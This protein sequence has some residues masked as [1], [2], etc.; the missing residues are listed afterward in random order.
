MK[1]VDFTSCLADE[2][3]HFVKFKQG[4]GSDYHSCAKLLFRFDQHLVALSFKSK[5]PTRPIFQNYFETINHLC[6]RGF[7]N[8]YSVLQQFSAWLS[9]H[10]TDGYVLERRRALDRSHSRPAYIFTV[11]QIKA[12]LDNSASFSK[13]KELIP[14][15]YQ[16]LF[17]L[18]YSTGIRIG[19]AL[20][21]THADYINDQRLIHIQ[22][23]KF[24]KQRYLVLSNS[25][26]NRLNEYIRHYK[27]ILPLEE[28]SPLFVNIRTKPLTYNSAY[29]A[30]IKTLNKSGINKNH[31]G[32]RL[33]DFRHRFAV[34]RL[35]QWYK[36][37]TDINA[38]L[39]FLSTY[40]GHV[41]ITSTQVYLQAANELLQAGCERF[42]NFFINHIK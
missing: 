42:H 17:S 21:L 15:V 11:D 23:G 26:A 24:R 19:E 10:Q 34:H 36:T 9:L 38:K 37:E 40:M 30:F 13:K 4:C 1:T 20:A 16:T 14:G 32:P 27:T 33:H 35:L 22:K 25:A 5:A 2:M 39:P 3:A 28:D 31:S 41:D 29:C 18:L 6:A 7:T 8:H 12:I